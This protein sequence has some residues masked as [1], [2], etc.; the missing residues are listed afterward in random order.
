MST[1][2]YCT[3]VLRTTWLQYPGPKRWAMLKAIAIEVRDW[4]SI[5]ATKTSS[6]IVVKGSPRLAI[7]CLCL[8]A[9]VSSRWSMVVG[10]ALGRAFQIILNRFLPSQYIARR[11]LPR[12]WTQSARSW[13]QGPR[14]PGPIRRC[15]RH[16]RCTA[17]TMLHIFLL[18]RSREALKQLSGICCTSIGSRVGWHRTSSSATVSWR[19]Q[20]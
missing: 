20:H 1:I 10:A 15:N 4:T 6:I 12:Q 5:E 18:G 13:K 7:S 17:I 16:R 9:H 19:A 3:L 14:R 8:S 11:K 2:R